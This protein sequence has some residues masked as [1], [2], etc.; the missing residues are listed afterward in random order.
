M[1]KGASPNARDSNGTSALTLAFGSG[2]AEKVKALVRLG[3]NIQEPESESPLLI[4]GK[5]GDVKML[6]SILENG[7]KISADTLTKVLVEAI[8]QGYRETKGHVET[9]RFLIT[10]G[11]DVNSEVQPGRLPLQVALKA[12]QPQ[13]FS[14]FL[15]GGA[16]P[17]KLV[18]CCTPALLKKPE[19]MKIFFTYGHKLDKQSLA[20]LLMEAITQGQ[21]ETVRILVK[22]GADADSEL[23]P[24]RLP[25]QVALK[26]DKPQIFSELLAAGADPNKLVSCCMPSLLKKEEFTKLL[27][28]QEDKVSPE[29]KE[30]LLKAG[31]EKGLPS[32][33]IATLKLGFKGNFKSDSGQPLLISASEKGYKDVVELLLKQ[34]AEINEPD[35]NGNTALM[36]SS[37]LGK[38]EIVKLLLDNGAKP[39]LKNGASSSALALACAKGRTEVVKLLLDNGADPALRLFKNQTSLMHAVSNNQIGAAKVLCMTPG[40]EINATDEDGHT[41]LMYA[42]YKGDRGLVRLLLEHKADINAQD[43]RGH[44]A[45]M[46]ASLKGNIQMIKLLLEHNADVNVKNKNGKTA[47]GL[48]DKAKQKE[49]VKILKDK[50][51]HY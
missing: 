7:P 8:P 21:V 22:Q 10:K 28:A 25:L 23:R 26:E 49:A 29:N 14:E 6:E 13:I 2:D 34:G 19:F 42:F 18:S 44:T 38:I 3:A 1:Q 48:A 40:I 15:A 16:D 43:E 32:V 45:L 24:G 33:A 46:F 36:E 20:E 27:L 17:N 37:R 35:R 51:A 9:V 47:L 30:K 11:A 50:G 39:N 31:V 41:A 4:A 12:D 5:K